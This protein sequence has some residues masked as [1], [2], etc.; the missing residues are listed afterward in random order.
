MN[1]TITSCRNSQNELIKIV[2]VTSGQFEGQ[3]LLVI[4]DDDSEGGTQAPHLLDAQTIQW[5]R[6]SLAFI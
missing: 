3:H 6:A 2:E 4:V 5:L 1:K